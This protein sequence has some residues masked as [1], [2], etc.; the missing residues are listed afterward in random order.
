MLTWKM[1][2]SRVRPGELDVAEVGCDAGDE[3]EHADGEQDD[4][5]QQ[6]KCLRQRAVVI[7]F[8]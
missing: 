8:P 2:R 4:A 1:P 6:R 7:G 3:P 5:E